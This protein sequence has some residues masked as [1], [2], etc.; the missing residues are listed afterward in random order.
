MIDYLRPSKSLFFM[1]QGTGPRRPCFNVSAFPTPNTDTPRDDLTLRGFLAHDGTA[2]TAGLRLVPTPFWVEIREGLKE[3][4]EET[5]RASTESDQRARALESETQ[6]LQEKINIL[7]EANVTHQSRLREFEPLDQLI[8]RFSA[9]QINL[10][11]IRAVSALSL[12]EAAMKR[13]LETLSVQIEGRPSFGELR[14]TLEQALMDKERRKLTPR[15]LG[16]SELAEMRNKIIH[17][18]HLFVALRQDEAD[19]VVTSVSNLIADMKFD[20]VD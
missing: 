4:V 17:S 8:Q 16:L 9:M 3:L 6:T 18:G 15:L 5:R 20:S 7:I 11:W 13:K 10:H 2:T 1:Q 14:R 19:S 12:I